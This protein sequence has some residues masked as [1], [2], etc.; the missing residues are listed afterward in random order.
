MLFYSDQGKAH[1]PAQL[2]DSLFRD[3]FGDRY[4]FLRLYAWHKDRN[5]QDARRLVDAIEWKCD[6]ATGSRTVGDVG[7]LGPEYLSGQLP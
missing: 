1:I 3:G 2:E 7:L 5:P 6:V 4:L